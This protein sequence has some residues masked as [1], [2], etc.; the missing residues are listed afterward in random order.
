M[1]AAVAA[2]TALS[3]CSHDV[4]PADA[5]SACT[6]AV[7]G[8]L[9]SPGSAQFPSWSGKVNAANSGRYD[10]ASYVD[11]QNALG[12]LVRTNWTCSVVHSGD[13]AKVASVVV[14]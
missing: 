6:K 13:V 12:G 14:G 8:Q 3:A 7:S 11:S 4:N 1:L 9:A 5:Y 2:V 10:I